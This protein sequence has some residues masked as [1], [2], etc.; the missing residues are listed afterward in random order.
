MEDRKDGKDT[1][2]I[3]IENFKI[4]R[5]RRKAWDMQR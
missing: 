1:F 5:M 3:K 4:S 2:R